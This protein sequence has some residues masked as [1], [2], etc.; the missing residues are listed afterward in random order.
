MAHPR[1]MILIGFLMLLLGGVIL[2]YLM[3]IHVIDVT[4]IN[5]VL[6]WVLIFGSYAMS[7]VGLFLG[8]I[9]FATYTRSKRTPK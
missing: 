7:V 4:A 5:E 1:R 2:P 8:V 3:T 6:A 9:G